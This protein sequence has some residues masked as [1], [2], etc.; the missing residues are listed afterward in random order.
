MILMFLKLVKDFGAMS[1]WLL[2]LFYYWSY[3]HQ[4]CMYGASY[5]SDTLEKQTWMPNLIQMFRMEKVKV[6]GAV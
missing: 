1:F 3:F 5:D 4:T 6:F 2:Y